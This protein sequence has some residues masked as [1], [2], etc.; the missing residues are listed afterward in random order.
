MICDI[1]G[2]IVDVFF[3][4]TG[5]RVGTLLTSIA[6]R[7]GFMYIA[8]IEAHITPHWHYVARAGMLLPLTCLTHDSL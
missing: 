7:M 6:Q 5:E 4:C 2:L 8:S 3:C 1:I